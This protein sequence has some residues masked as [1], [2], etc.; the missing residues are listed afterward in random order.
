[1]TNISVLENRI[2][3]VRRYLKLVARYRPYSREQIESNV[4]IRG[5]VE[6]YLYLAIQAAIHLAEAFIA[7]KELRKPSTFSE[8]FHVLNENETVPAELTQRLVKM[9]C[10]RDIV[11]HDYEDMNYD[12]VYDILQNR[13]NDIAGFVEIIAQELSKE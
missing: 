8:C 13:V 10:F 3:A 5:A 7:Y 12:I 11:V 9:V 2:S 1:M 6:R 4:D